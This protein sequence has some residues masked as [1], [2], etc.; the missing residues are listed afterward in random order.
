MPQMADNPAD[1]DFFFLAR[2]DPEQVLETIVHLVAERIPKG[3]GLDPVRDIQV[4]S[5][6]HR[7]LV[8]AEN[9]NR[10]LQAR[11]NPSAPQ[12]VRGTQ[13]LKI[14]DK[15]MQIRN[16][17]DKEVFNGDIG[18][19]AAIDTAAPTVT[20]VF[21]A[22]P[23][24]YDA[25]ELDEIVLAYAVSVHKSQGSEFPAVIVPVL[26]Q[27]Y[28][29]LQR[30]LLYTAVTRGRRLVVVVGT[31]KAVALAVKNASQRERYSALATRL[32]QR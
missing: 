29:L 23:V 1:S 32:R 17:Y 2:E 14:N 18:T 13:A 28:I 11:L 30:N 15:V 8:G 12:L 27:H 9:L 10:T 3:F 6:M 24:N 4:L 5:P 21:D 31:R 26:T 22:R 25:A 20:V 7:G 19:I 16:N